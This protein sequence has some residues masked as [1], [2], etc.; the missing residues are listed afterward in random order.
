MPQH[1]RRGETVSPAHPE[2]LAWVRAG[3][4]KLDAALDA[5]P[6]TAVHQPSALPDWT[7]GHVLSHLARNADALINLLTWARTGQRSP[8]YASPEQRNADIDA[9]APRELA[10]QRTDVRASAE[11]FLLAAD[12][13]TEQQWLVTV[14]SAQG[15]EIP[16]ADIPWLRAREVW[17]HL[18]DLD[19]G[20]GADAWPDDFALA[21]VHDVAGW[22]SG[23]LEAGTV[24]E[25]AGHPAVRLGPDSAEPAGT[26]SG[27]ANDLAAWLTGRSDGARLHGSLP[28]LPRWL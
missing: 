13:L 5:L 8:M 21:L 18:V 6:E 27:T 26:V 3:E 10:E 24:L 17:I 1:L 12:E 9:G 11:R 7:R 16:A 28:T 2:S 23:K 25:P 14:Q 15:R 4:K 19:A 22:M 20:I